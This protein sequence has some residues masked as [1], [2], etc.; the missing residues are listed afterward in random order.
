MVNLAVFGGLN[1]VLQRIAMRMLEWIY[2]GRLNMP[3][4]EEESPMRRAWH[5]PMA[6]PLAIGIVAVEIWRFRMVRGAGE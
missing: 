4:P 3:A 1:A 2:L 5:I 6:I